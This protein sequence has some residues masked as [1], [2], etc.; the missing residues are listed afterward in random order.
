LISRLSSSSGHN[1]PMTTPAVPSIRY[2]RL[3]SVVAIGGA[4]NQLVPIC[5]VRLPDV[6]PNVVDPPL[7]IASTSLNSYVTAEANSPTME[8][9]RTHP[10][11]H[12][13]P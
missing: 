3:T 4:A 9:A 12:E 13:A 2:T 7:L 1:K 8:S 5:C 10:P 6:L 11:S